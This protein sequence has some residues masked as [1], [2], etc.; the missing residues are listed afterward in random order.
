MLLMKV[1]FTVRFHFK[2]LSAKM[3]SLDREEGD[4]KVP[5]GLVFPDF[6]TSQP[7]T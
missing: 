5:G 4:K 2:L 7:G 6:V 3:S 1:Y